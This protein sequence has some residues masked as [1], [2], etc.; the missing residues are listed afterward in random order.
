M[1]IKELS[2]EATASRVDIESYLT[3]N[4][5]LTC[6]AAF[7]FFFSGNIVMPAM[8]LYIQQLG[9]T[10]GEIGFVMSLTPMIALFA[11]P[12]AGVLVDK[13]FITGLLAFGGLSNL[14]TAVSCIFITV[15][16]VFAGVRM[17][18]GLALASFTTAAG[19][20]IA[21]DAPARRRGEAIGIFGIM[22]PVGMAFGPTL[23]M[24][25]LSRGGFTTLFALSAFLSFLSLALSLFVRPPKK[26]RTA[27][28]PLKLLNREALLPSMV[29]SAATFAMGAM[30]A[31]IPLYVVRQNLGD[32]GLFF[33]VHAFSMI[34]IR[35][36]AGKLSDTYGRVVLIVPGVLG[37]ALANLYLATNPGYI[38]ML[39]A[40][41]MFGAGA[42]AAFPSILALAIDRAHATERGSAMATLGA[43]FDVGLAIGTLCGGLILQW[44]G[45]GAM[46]LANGLVPV[47][48]L[49]L[50]LLLNRRSQRPQKSTAG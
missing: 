48:G 21:D 13:A 42:G 15:V 38:G 46:F 1:S 41:A 7:F 18:S 10:E 45:F 12:F 33:T 36:T 37:V 8:P 11:R 9:G 28:P 49:V 35:L 32:P 25:V 6:L 50:F 19:T 20:S 16:W 31:F 5:I 30:F 4:F 40:G 39:L 43:S 27:A 22:G 2:R 44:G 26:E 29:Q 34:F 17:F 24:A 23:G 14:A 3:K 47:L